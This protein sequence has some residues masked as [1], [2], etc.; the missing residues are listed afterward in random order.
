MV[1]RLVYGLM[2]GLAL[3]FVACNRYS[4]PINTSSY[5]DLDGVLLIASKDYWEGR[6]GDSLRHYLAAPFPVLP[7]YEPSLDIR[8]E[9]PQDLNNVL[10]TRRVVMVLAN[11]QDTADL[12]T[13]FLYKHL[14]KANI[15]KALAQGSHLAFHSNR[16]AGGQLVI[17]WFG[18][19]EADL[20]ASI[21]QESPKILQRIQ[22]FDA[23][24]LQDQ[25]YRDGYCSP[26]MEALAARDF[27]IKIPKEYRIARA[28]SSVVWLRLETNQVSSNLFFAI[29]PDTLALLPESLKTRRDSL[30]ARYFS[31]RIE[32]SYM[33]I[34]DRFIKPQIEAFRWQNLPAL[35]MRGIWYMVNDF[36]GGPFMTYMVHDTLRK[37]VV[38]IDGFIHAPN[39]RK[40][41]ELR[42]LEG[43]F[44]TLKF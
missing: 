38:L 11:V 28:D 5:G 34:D 39:V 30:T 15:D 44:T 23:P 3:L 8:H 21:R 7:R 2:L 41:P 29:Y 12:T 37:R 42:R 24:D 16:W 25:L 19:S 33:Q 18:T 10:L 4:G 14:G 43:I 13:Q 6:L 17:Y 22:N 9:R 40:R 27:N 32:G 36:M 26:C 35:E 31:S 20:L 1:F